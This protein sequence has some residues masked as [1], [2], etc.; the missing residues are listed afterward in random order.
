MNFKID[1]KIDSKIDKKIQRSKE[2]KKRKAFTA[3]TLVTCVT[4]TSV[5]T[6]TKVVNASSLK[7]NEFAKSNLRQ[8]INSKLNKSS[9]LTSTELINYDTSNYRIVSEDAKKYTHSFIALDTV[10]QITIY[11]DD[12]S[13][14]V[15]KIMDETESL[16]KEYENV[17]SKTISG[18]FT[19]TLNSTGEYDYSQSPYADAIHQLVDKSKYYSEISN[20]EFDV[21]IEPVVRLWDINNGNT[22]IPSQNDLDKAL[23][24]V[25][26][27]NFVRD[28]NN[29]KY[30][31]LNGATV[32]FGGI[33]K[34]QI[35]DIIKASLMSKGINSGLVSL[36][37]NVVTIGAKPGDK[38]WVIG[39]QDPTASSGS[40]LGTVSVKNKSIVS[41]G[42][43]ER[44]FVKDGERYHHIMDTTTGYP[45]NTGLVQ[46][47]I[48]SDYSIDGDGLSTTTFLL[49]TEEGLELIE[50]LDGVEAMFIDEE[51]NFY[52]SENF[53]DNYNF[54]I[55]E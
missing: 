13:I 23:T 26:Y 7:P 38:N 8:Y 10:I 17:I 19:H 21:T 37:G 36:G 31:L 15:E 34:G 27:N 12:P 28:E 16:V 4:L 51:M 3:L 40:I 22:E 25:D 43:Y 14:D 9:E 20:G 5:A 49:G 52:F 1:F 54:A 24:S 6:F 46:T 42:N 45:S 50:N 30:E 41:S 29:Q 47:T 53:S 11:N 33:G 39:I 32:D 48:I 55:S 18:S 44:Y 35:A 2:R